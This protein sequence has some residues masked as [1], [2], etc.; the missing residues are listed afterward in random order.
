[1]ATRFTLL[2]STGDQIASLFRI[3]STDP[4]SRTRAHADTEEEAH[5]LAMGYLVKHP[6]ASVDVMKRTSVMPLAYRPYTS[7]EITVE[8]YTR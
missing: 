3:E 8:V 2:E 1:M 6:T 4:D 5:H 7:Y